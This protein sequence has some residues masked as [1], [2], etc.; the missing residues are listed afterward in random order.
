MGELTSIY[1]ILAAVAST[2]ML[3]TILIPNRA[4]HNFARNSRKHNI[5]QCHFIDSVALSGDCLYSDHKNNYLIESEEVDCEGGRRD[6]EMP[7]LQR[8]L[9]QFRKMEND[10]IFDANV[11]LINQN[12][13]FFNIC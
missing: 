2:I 5:N 9:K 4:E 12:H 1:I 13:Y 3:G 8:T 7:R 6:A 11:I 10:S